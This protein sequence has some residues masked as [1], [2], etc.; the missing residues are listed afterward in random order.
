LEND[1]INV[2]NSSIEIVAAIETD[3][4]NTHGVI[5][6]QGGRFGGWS[7]YVKDNKPVYTYNYLGLD[8]SSVSGKSKLPKGKSIIKLEFAYDGGNPGSGGLATLYVNGKEEGSV[9]IEKT[10][11]CVFS[12]DETANIGLDK[13]TMVTDDYDIEESRFSAKIEKVTIAILE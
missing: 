13:E 3:G 2:K 6:A 12:G 7:L 10:E 9:R 8:L 5:V 4:D 1:F 11:C